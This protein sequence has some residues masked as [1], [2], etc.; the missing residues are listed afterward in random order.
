MYSYFAKTR[1]NS[2][3]VSEKY[4]HVNNFGYDKGVQKMQVDRESGRSDY[5]LIYVKNGKM[6]YTYVEF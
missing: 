4:I 1:K 6:V 3:A 5:Q 2:D